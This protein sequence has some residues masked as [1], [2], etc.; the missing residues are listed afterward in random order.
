MGTLCAVWARMIV[1]GRAEHP[2]RCFNQVGLGGGTVPAK[3]LG[4]NPSGI[5]GHPNPIWTTSCKCA[6]DM[7]AVAID[8]SSVGCERH[9]LRGP[10]RIIMINSRLPAREATVVGP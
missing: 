6:S 7:C 9:T 4:M 10:E 2:L 1:S 5:R 3:G 8:V